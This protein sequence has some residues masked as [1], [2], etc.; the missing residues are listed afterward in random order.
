MPEYNGKYF[1]VS[2]VRTNE[3][4]AQMIG[5]DSL[6]EAKIQYHTEVAYGL[7]LNDIILAHYFVMNE[8][9][10]VMENLETTIDNIPPVEEPKEAEE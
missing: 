9:G 6:K 1:F 3:V 10:V 8:F 4:A 5:F 7:Q 2:N